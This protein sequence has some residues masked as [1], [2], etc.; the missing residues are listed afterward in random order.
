M[1]DSTSP[2][3][4][5]PP[6]SPRSPLPPPSPPAP[7]PPPPPSAPPPSSPATIPGRR[8]FHLDPGR[9]CDLGTIVLVNLAALG[10]L[11]HRLRDPRSTAVRIDPAPT[12]TAVRLAVHV[13][14]AVLHPAVVRLPAGARVADAVAA[15][16]GLAADASPALNLAAPLTDG[17]QVDVPRVGEPAPAAPA[18]AVLVPPAEAAPAGAG[19]PVDLNRATAAELDALPGV[20][21]AVAAR[22]VAY[23]S[24]NGPF[25]SAEDLLNVA[26]IGDRTLE[27][28][29]PGVVVR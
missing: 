9:L 15:A 20:G 14:G 8:R 16:G 23:R 19:Q 24:A 18:H 3:T 1:T 21:P 25:R 6:P 11:V 10:L 26:G 2:Q 22:I 4:P 13:T 28:L 29:R 5:L 17:D 7:S 12:P 27:R